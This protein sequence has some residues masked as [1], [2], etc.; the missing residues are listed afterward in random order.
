[1]RK[2]RKKESYVKAVKTTKEERKAK[3]KAD[4]RFAADTKGK[5]I[6]QFEKLLGMI[7]MIVGLVSFLALCVQSSHYGTGHSLA[8]S[9]FIC[10]IAFGGMLYY[11]ACNAQKR[12]TRFRYY[13][14][15]LGEKEY[16][17]LSEM[18][19][20]TGRPSGS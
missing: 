10:L 1:M 14:S 12:M 20:I 8:H 16:I 17:M 5:W 19:S 7:C 6:R 18:E 13:K 9:F 15:F 11:K 4:R 2:N 3:K